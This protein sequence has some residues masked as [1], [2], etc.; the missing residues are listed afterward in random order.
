MDGRSS[1]DAVLLDALNA[2]ASRFWCC[3]CHGRFALHEI[4][5][6]VGWHDI[7]EY[8]AGQAPEKFFVHQPLNS[9]W[10]RWVLGPLVDLSHKLFGGITQ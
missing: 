4:L 3:G 5:L 2:S 10:F 1:A 7:V 9:P 6:L 8:F